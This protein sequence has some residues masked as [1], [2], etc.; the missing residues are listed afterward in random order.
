MVGT[1]LAVYRDLETVK[2]CLISDIC[3]LACLL[4]LN[5]IRDVIDDSLNA[6]GIRDLR[7]LDE[8]LGLI[9]VILCSYRKRSFTCIV[10]GFHLI[11]VIEDLSASRKVRRGHDLQKIG[12]GISH[13]CFSCS[14]YFCKIE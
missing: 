10:N 6:C 1:S 2:V 9:N 5:E 11:F 8:V 14:A 3:D 4:A 13:V 12:I 7:N